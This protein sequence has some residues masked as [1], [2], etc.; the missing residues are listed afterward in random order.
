[1][2]YK[3][4]WLLLCLILCLLFTANSSSFGRKRDWI[5][6][7]SV[8]VR[9]GLI[10]TFVKRYREFR[11]GDRVLQEHFSNDTVSG[12]LKRAV[13]GISR[14]GGN[15]PGDQ[16]RGQFNGYDI[17]YEYQKY[18]TKYLYK[19]AFQ[20]LK[21]KEKR[22][23]F[24]E[25]NNLNVSFAIDGQGN[26]INWNLYM[27][28][29]FYGNISTRTIK[30]IGRILTSA[31]FLPFTEEKDVWDNYGFFLFRSANYQGKFADFHKKGKIGKA[32]GN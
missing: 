16:I 1:M 21:K 14:V 3:K 26:V 5:G 17:S 27:V 15:P 4:I 25:G 11:I 8:L 13:Y 18:A 28:K 30:K 19:Q 6:K 12:R 31:K 23:C 22:R 7:D 20:A 24:V 9:H 32:K 10:Q 29:P 2:K